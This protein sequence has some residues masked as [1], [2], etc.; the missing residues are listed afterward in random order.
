MTPTRT[1]Q[2]PFI[3]FNSS[4]TSLCALSDLLSEK[5]R[6]LPR[7]RRAANIGS[8]VILALATHTTLAQEKPPDGLQR[9]TNVAALNVRPQASAPSIPQSVSISD[10]VAIFL[11]QNFQLI[12]ARYDIDSAAPEKL[13]A[14]FRP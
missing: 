1:R 5:H 12:A 10:A 6:H 11:R 3:E 13:T 8:L 14:R 9:Q 7:R 4:A 2:I